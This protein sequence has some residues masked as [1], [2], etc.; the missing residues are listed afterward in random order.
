MCGRRAGKTFILALTAVFLAC[1]RDWRPI[2]RPRRARHHHGHRRR[3]AAGAHHHALREGPAE[4]GA[5]ARQ[6]VEA[7][8][9]GESI[10]LANRVTIEVHTASFRAV[11]GYTVVAALLDEMAFWRPVRTAANPDSEVIER[12]P[13]G[14]GDG[15]WRHAAVRLIALRAAR[16]AVGGLSH[17]TSARTAV[18]WSGRR[19]R[20]TMNPTVT[21]SLHR[22]RD[23]RRTR[24]RPPPS[25]GAQFRTDIESYVSREA[26]EAVIEWGVHERGPLHGKRYAAFVDP[27]GGSGDSFTLAIAHKE[28][29][30]AV[31][32]CVREVRPPFSPRASCRS[33]AD[34]LKTL[35]DHEGHEATATPASCRASCSPSRASSTS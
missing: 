31:L 14:N 4:V 21:Q 16:R 7:E 33:S 3:P 30:I 25:I 10:D 12:H 1:F 19:R 20:G 23:T 8:T 28:G 32:D 27:S 24:S 29:E 35:S 5:D 6:T 11:R 17:A 26:V 34:L 18:R 22:R 9:A 13:A 15:P 2:P